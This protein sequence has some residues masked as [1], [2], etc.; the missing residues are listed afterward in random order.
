MHVMIDLETLGTRHDATIIQLGAVLFEARP[1]GKLHNDKGL[2]RYVLVQDGMGSVDN[3]TIAWWLQ[4]PNAAKVGKA[5]ETEAVPIGQA[6]AEF[7]DLPTQLGLTWDDVEGV[8][9]K[10]SS[11]NVA[12]LAMAFERLGSPPPWHHW[13]TRCAK[14]LFELTGG[15]PEVDWTGLTPHDALDD[16]VGQAMQVQKALAGR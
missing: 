10:P 15:T 13:S 2:N 1:R 8:W 7:T 6:L 5:L 9:A 4:Q 16:A 12:V 14:T 3:G 11:F